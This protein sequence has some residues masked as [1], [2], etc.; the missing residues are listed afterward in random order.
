MGKSIVKEI[1]EDY[2][3]TLEYLKGQPIPRNEKDYYKHMGIALQKIY[4]ILQIE[5]NKL[6]I[7]V[8]YHAIETLPYEKKIQL[9]NYVT[10]Q[11]ETERQR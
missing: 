9:L 11:L 4:Q 3:I 8:L 10:N 2:A 5:P 7:Y 6:L 1:E